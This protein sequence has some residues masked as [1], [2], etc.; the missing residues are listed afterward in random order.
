M[1]HQDRN[2]T[3]A[4]ILRLMEKPYAYD[5]FAAVRRIEVQKGTPSRTGAG[6]RLRDDPVRFGQEPSLAFAPSTLHAYTP[7]ARGEPDRMQVNF[8]GLFGPHGPLPLHLTEYARDRERNARD[9]SFVRFCDIFNHRMIAMFYR[10]WA[11]N[12]AAVSFDRIAD[13]PESDRFGFY[14]ASTIGLAEQTLRRRDGVPDIA[15]QHFSGR[16]SHQT[17]PPE[18]VAAILSDY[19]GMP[20]RIEEFVGQWIEIPEADRLRFGA[21][22]A[23]GRLG[24]SAVVGARTWDCTQ[25]FRIVI[26]P[27]TFEQF[28]RLLP[29]GRSFA[30]L[31]GWVRNY[32]GYEYNW[33][34][35]VILKRGEV[36]A[37][38][39]GG[40]GDAPPAMLG[41]TTWLKTEPFERDADNLVLRAPDEGE[42]V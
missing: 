11:V 36:P 6:Q 34:A 7:G 4:L 17:K 2:A 27:L 22:P 23:I 32:T 26:G 12:H 35:Q 19:F 20:C 42:M 14:L 39:L 13:D 1:A 10:A 40:S 30:R 33:D 3:Y 24:E 8:M 16:L 29:S 31:V 28:C 38:R 5:F 18:G 37:T 9:K 25:K 15:K 21:D 41:W